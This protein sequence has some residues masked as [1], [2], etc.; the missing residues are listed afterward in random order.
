MWDYFS[1]TAREFGQAVNTKLEL[2]SW[3][4]VS[5]GNNARLTRYISAS[6]GILTWWFHDLPRLTYVCF[7]KCNMCKMYACGC[8]RPQKMC[9][10][11]NYHSVKVVF[12]YHQHLQT[13]SVRACESLF[14]WCF[15]FSAYVSKWK[16]AYR[17]S[18]ATVVVNFVK[19]INSYRQFN[20]FDSFIL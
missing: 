4:K 15:W 13:S 9:P 7:L 19:R 10:S 6:R 8:M 11:S 16:I 20:T 17:R 2:I 5:I 3:K 18:W 12:L 14:L 1:E